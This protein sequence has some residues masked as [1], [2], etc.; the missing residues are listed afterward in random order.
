MIETSLKLNRFHLSSV[1]SNFLLCQWIDSPIFQGEIW[2][3]YTREKI[4]FHIM[5][6]LALVFKFLQLVGY[7]VL[8][9]QVLR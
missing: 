9:C 3:K 2:G 5:A 8:A 1:Y 7:I 4:K 6:K